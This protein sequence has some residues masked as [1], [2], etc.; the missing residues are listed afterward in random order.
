MNLP[1]EIRERIYEFALCPG[2][3]YPNG[4]PMETGRRYTAAM[5]NGVC[6]GELVYQRPSL[7]LLQT[8]G[9]I[10]DEALPLYL[11]L[12]RFVIQEGDLFESMRFL[13]ELPDEKLKYIRSIVLPFTPGDLSDRE[14]CA[15]KGEAHAYMEHAIGGWARFSTA[16]RQDTIHVYKLERLH[17]I[18][19]EK[20]D[21]VTRLTTLTD[22]VLDFTGIECPIGC[23]RADTLALSTAK[24][25]GAFGENLPYSWTAKT[26]HDLD[27]IISV[28]AGPPYTL[29]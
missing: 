12:N 2:E 26:E 10:H 3:V 5:M 1:L 22:L 19:S 9:Q 4:K 16:E 8:C 13:T 27:E 28:I 29:D 18:W 20:Y 15:A 17:Q 14:G 25:L 24:R 11:S 23:C 7:A 21:Y 6:R